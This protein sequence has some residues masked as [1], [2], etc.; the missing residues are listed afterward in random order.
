VQWRFKLDKTQQWSVTKARA[1]G[2]VSEIVL[3]DGLQTIIS[4]IGVYYPDGK[5]TQRVGIIPDI[6]V[7]LTIKGVREKNMN[8]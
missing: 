1:H 2:N 6:V 3:S 5:A 7:H 4:G 8:F